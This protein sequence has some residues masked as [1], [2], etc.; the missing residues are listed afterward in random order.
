M[1]DDALHK[2]EISQITVRNFR[3]MKQ[4]GKKIAILTAYDFPTAKILDEAGIDSI[5]VGDSSGS[6]VAGHKTTLPVTMDE[7]IYLTQN[8]TRAVRRALVIGDM[9]F[10]SYQPSE[11]VAITNAGR[12]LKEGGAQAV[13][14]EGGMEVAALIHHMVDF[15]IPVMGHIGLTPQSVNKFGGY[16]VMGKTERQQQYLL[17]SAQALQD[18][19]CFAIV[20]ESVITDVAKEISGSIRIPTIGIGAGPHCDGQVLVI[21]DM[22]G[23]FEEFRPKFVRAYANVA[24]IIR[25]ATTEYIDDV[26]NGKFPNKDESY[27]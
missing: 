2:E 17:Q 11:E 5:L 27:G 16:L 8:V 22:I 9:P 21:S 25:K 12:F 24:N 3:R 10:M 26:K 20:L 1:P 14:L 4:E 18:A 13:K 15:G 23:L 19:G 6:V 7:M